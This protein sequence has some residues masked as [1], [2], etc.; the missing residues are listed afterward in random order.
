MTAGWTVELT[1]GGVVESLHAVSVV[2]LRDGSPVYSAGDAERPV[3]GRSALK[4]AQVVA[5]LE[6]GTDLT[7]A[8][9]ALAAG[10]HSGEPV[11]LDAVRALLERHGLGP[12]AL[13]C[14]PDLPLG[15]AA[16]RALLGAGGTSSPLAM[17]CSGKH[18][19]MLAGAASMGPAPLRSASRGD[20]TYLD[21]AHP[22]QVRVRGVVERLA[23]PVLAASVD[24][25]GAPAFATSLLSLARLAACLGGA[26]PGT[27]EHRVATAMRARPDLVAGTDRLDTV[28]MTEVPGALGKIGAEGVLLATLPEGT[29]VAVKVHDG[30]SR[31]VG[32]V[33]LEVLR[34]A[35]VDVPPRLEAVASPPVLGG[36]Q[37]VGVVRV[38]S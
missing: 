38:R 22:L 24:G 8:E 30:A 20:P 2:V 14:P 1:R 4:P 28:L 11:H 13:R 25:C 7:D 17:N 31:A 6:A 18:A 10:S 12:D 35:R 33:L 27:A 32:P 9:V 34:R 36:G 23:G 19:A 37:P 16:A 15:A 29:A 26:A 21:P 5:V 3:Y